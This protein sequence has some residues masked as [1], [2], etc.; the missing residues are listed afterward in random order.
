MKKYIRQHTKQGPAIDHHKQSSFGSAH[1]SVQAQPRR[2]S[3]YKHD[4]RHNAAVGS[5]R[6]LQFDLR[7]RIVLRQRQWCEEMNRKRMERK[8]KEA[9]QCNSLRG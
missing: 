1:T 3:R 9:V 6:A 8:C 2:G 7:A 4:L 5:G